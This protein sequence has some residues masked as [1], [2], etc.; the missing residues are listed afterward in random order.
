M[1]HGDYD[2]ANLL[3]D[4]SDG[5]WKISG[6]LD[7]EFAY[8]A[9]PLQDMA[10]MLRYAH[11]MPPLYETAFVL[12]VQNGGVELPDDWRLRIDLLN[13]LNLLSCLVRCPPDQRPNQCADICE[14][15]EH[16]LTRIRLI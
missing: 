12:G 6:V 11:H 8:S 10:L 2:P 7:W 5:Q 15:I 14:L 13:I 9:S 16:I 3:V 1:V 4:R